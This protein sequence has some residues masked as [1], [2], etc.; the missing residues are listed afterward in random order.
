VVKGL[1][2]PWR[3]WH[4]FGM[5]RAL[6][7]CRTTETNEALARAGGQ[8]ASWELLTPGRALA[9]LQPGDAALGRLDVV[10]TLDGMDDGLWALG[11]LAARGVVILNDP[12]ALL[13]AHDKLLTARVLTRRGVPHPRT[14]LVRAGRPLPLLG[15]E[16]V[17][18][19]RFGS[20]GR[21][22][23]RCAGGAEL[24]AAVERVRD[25]SWFRRHGALVQEL[26]PPRGYDL[27]VVVAA[28]R[29]IGAAYRIAADGEWRTN[30][31]LGGVRRAAVDPPRGAV[32]LAL[33]AAQA[34][35]TSLA[36]ID[37]L[38]DG[39]GGWTVL[40][41]N[42]AV[43][44]TREYAPWGDIFADAAVALA[45]EA[46]ERLACREAPAAAAV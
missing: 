46:H 29:M 24:A 25:T 23:T 38:P 18:K 6:I 30:V 17:L 19:P 9:E 35:G 22:V 31:A 13:A 27:R 20:W 33:A 42:G 3:A 2:Q 16:V 32:A 40:E 14:T 44:F 1:V 4:D 8:T 15:R 37:L 28:G 39:D 12:S 21:E 34:T 7:A 26:V 5:R 36:G 41:V 45:G 10:P 43:E 11:A